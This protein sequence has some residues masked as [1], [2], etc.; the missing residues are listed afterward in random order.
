MIYEKLLEIQAEIPPIEKMGTN[1]HFKSKYVTLPVLLKVI[2]PILQK[3]KVTYTHL[4]EGGSVVCILRDIKDG[5]EI[6]STLD[7]SQFNIPDLQ[8]LGS[9][10]TYSR[11]YLL[12]AMLGIEEDDDDANEAVKPVEQSKTVVKAAFPDKILEPDVFGLIEKA[13][14]VET[15]NKIYDE[16]PDLQKD[17]AFIAALKTKKEAIKGST[18]ILTPTVELNEEQTKVYKKLVT[19]VE[20]LDK[21]DQAGAKKVLKKIEGVIEAGLI[22]KEAFSDALMNTLTVQEAL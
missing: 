18:T 3:H 22:P 20:A 10:I 12:S 11:R 4:L 16:N 19:E 15:L 17:K 2:K 9:A 14:V 7:L 13:T 5:D 8:K 1:P 6:R 21:E